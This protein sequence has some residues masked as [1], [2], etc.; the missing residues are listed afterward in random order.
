MACRRCGALDCTPSSWA[1]LGEGSG[2][3]G[4]PPEPKAVWF[5][6]QWFAATCTLCEIF[7]N[8]RGR[9]RWSDVSSDK[10]SEVRYHALDIARRCE[11][12]TNRWAHDRGI[13]LPGQPVTNSADWDR[14][15]GRGRS[16][17][18]GK[19]PRRGPSAPPPFKAA[20]TTA[21]TGSGSGGCSRPAPPPPPPPQGGC[22]RPPT[23]GPKKPSPKEEARAAAE[24]KAREQELRRAVEA[25]LAPQPG[26]DG[27]RTPHPQGAATPLPQGVVKGE[28]DLWAAYQPS[29]LPRVLEV[30]QG[31]QAQSQPQA[32]QGEG[33]QEPHSCPRAFG[34][35]ASSQ[36][37][38]RAPLEPQTPA[39]EDL[40]SPPGS[41]AV[42]TGPSG[43]NWTGPPQVQAAV[44]RF[45]LPIKAPPTSR[46]TTP[47]EAAPVTTPLQ[48]A[49]ASPLWEA[50]PRR[51]ATRRTV[52]PEGRRRQCPRHLVRR[53]RRR[54]QRR[55]TI[56][57]RGR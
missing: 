29:Y 11:T 41:S 1:P 50:L 18:R 4:P 39:T 36:E 42:P 9:I 16:P 22:A 19:S 37:G 14:K 31:C 38:L 26:A 35:A 51:R 40:L 34:P 55:R 48:A 23:E 46:A 33:L 47:H 15:G 8:I 52:R 20:P 54:R 28:A 13:P 45:G 57:P 27:W 21:G 56:R 10:D 3:F 2:E 7:A 24:W 12:L 6:G 5:K 49:M 32:S 17:K 25:G 53:R 43:S 44:G 30:M